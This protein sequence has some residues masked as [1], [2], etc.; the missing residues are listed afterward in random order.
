M[1]QS[2]ATVAPD[3]V[4]DNAAGD[5]NVHHIPVDQIVASPF[6]PRSTFDQVEL[7]QLADSLVADGQMQ[8]IVVRKR[9]LIA[10]CNDEN[11]NDA[12][13]ELVAG[14]R[15]WR[16]AQVAGLASIRAMVVDVDDKKAIELAGM[17]NYQRAQLNDIEQA[18]WFETMIEQAG[19]T[20]KKL[21][22]KL[23]ITQAQVSQRL[24]LL[25]LPN[26]W[27]TALITGVIPFTWARE[28]VPWTDH[29]QI[30]KR[31]R[32]DIGKD[33]PGSLNEFQ[34]A[35]EDAIEAMSRPIASGANVQFEDN[36]GNYR[37]TTVAFKPTKKQ[38]EELQL[39]TV[40]RDWGGP[41]KRALNIE[42]WD[43]LQAAGEQRRAQRDA[44]AAAKRDQGGQAAPKGSPAQKRALAKKQAEQLERKMYAWKIRWYQN[45]IAEHLRSDSVLLPTKLRLLLFFASQQSP[46]IRNQDLIASASELGV[47]EKKR[48]KSWYA[49]ADTWGT[50]SGVE[51]LQLDDLVRS[52]LERW[53]QHDTGSYRA[54]L[55]PPDVEA[56]ADDLGI[57]IATEWELDRSYLELHTTAQLQALITEWK[58]GKHKISG[59]RTDIIDG[60]LAAKPTTPPKALIKAKGG[61]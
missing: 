14:E 2:T 19:Y 11:G 9:L 24:A 57:D 41:Q 55:Q 50:I 31:L 51:Q 42:L 23:G 32:A 47:R 59:K 43:Q 1:I 49:R 34:G 3:R 58:L 22:E 7:H 21:G 35:L 46:E 16:A 12:R 29:P 17:E 39:I 53:V 6:N 15:R 54:D 56:I 5:G 8:N 27:Q 48:G 26:D 38:K 45:R 28:L 52:V 20:Q 36:D 33:V 13:Y 25:K 18:R 4:A 37:W 44:A 10:R 30:L 61:R 60:I 40:K